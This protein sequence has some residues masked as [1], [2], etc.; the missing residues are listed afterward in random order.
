MLP[1]NTLNYYLAVLENLVD[2]KHNIN[3]L[4]EEEMEPS[5][6]SAAEKQIDLLIVEQVE[7]LVDEN[8]DNA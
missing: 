3:A 6:I 5:Y 8:K 2:I 4:H 7:K 1:E